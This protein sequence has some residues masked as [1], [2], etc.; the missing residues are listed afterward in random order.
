MI[1]RDENIMKMIIPFIDNVVNFD[2]PYLDNINDLNEL[3][4]NKYVTAIRELDFS[5]YTVTHIK[6]KKASWY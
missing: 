6:E 2:Y 3:E 4:F 1:L 5:N